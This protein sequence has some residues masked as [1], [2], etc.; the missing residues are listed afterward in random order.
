MLEAEMCIS[1][2]GASKRIVSKE[3]AKRRE[4]WVPGGQR[5]T[6]KDCR[7]PSVTLFLSWL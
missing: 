1:S 7:A 6:G 5:A 2:T 3:D 4:G